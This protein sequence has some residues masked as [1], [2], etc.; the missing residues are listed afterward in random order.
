MDAQSYARHPSAIAKTVP[1]QGLTSQDN[2]E[3]EDQN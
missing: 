2:I 3:N 1:L